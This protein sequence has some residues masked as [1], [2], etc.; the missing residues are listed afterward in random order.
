MQRDS[1]LSARAPLSAFPISSRNDSQINFAGRPTAFRSTLPRDPPGRAREI[2]ASFWIRL[3]APSPRCR[4]HSSWRVTSGTYGQ[5]SMGGSRLWP[6]RRARRCLDCFEKSV[7]QPIVPSPVDCG[8]RLRLWPSRCR[9]S[10]CS[11]P[12][13]FDFDVIVVGGGHAGT[14]AAAMCARLNAHTLLLTSN[15]ETIGQ[16]SCNP[17]IGGIAKRPETVAG[18]TR[19][20]SSSPPAHS[21]AAA[22]TSAPTHKS[23]PA[24]PAMRR[25]LRWHKSLRRLGLQ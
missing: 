7:R 21:S 3:G 14:E 19:A 22:F 12:P 23:P 17:A 4:P 11:F 20:P 18:S 5:L 2:T 24:V 25:P 9:S 15:L 8:P 1:P 16:M 10:L 13:M 6:P